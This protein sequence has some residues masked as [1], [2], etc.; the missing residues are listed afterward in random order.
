IKK[1]QDISD[2]VRHLSVLCNIQYRILKSR[3]FM[4]NVSKQN[5]LT[6]RQPYII[7]YYYKFSF[8]ILNV[9]YNSK[10]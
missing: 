7:R 10:L 3:A 6:N 4:K 2:N 8:T 5:K 1:K 9:F